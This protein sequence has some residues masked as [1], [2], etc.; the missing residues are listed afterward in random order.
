MG[1]VKSYI[2]AVWARGAFLAVGRFHPST[3]HPALVLIFSLLVAF[4]H[5][6]T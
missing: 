3:V 5:Y 2:D 1:Q 6:L 4:S